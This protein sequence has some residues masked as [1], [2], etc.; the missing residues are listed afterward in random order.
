MLL[1]AGRDREDVR[2]EDDV[3]RRQAD[4]LREDAISAR[5]DLHLAVERVRLA[6]LVERHHHNRRAVPLDQ[7]RVALEGLLTFFQA[8]RVHDRLA[9]HA[10][11]PFLD[12]LPLRAVHHQR[13][14]RDVRFGGDQLQERGH[15]LLRVEHG[16]VHVHVH[17]LRAALDLLPGDR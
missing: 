7:A 13:D 16:L 2:V 5:A 15:R 3:L 10:L 4:L 1:D 11:Q 12:H 14:A 8:D 9:L 6:D 17:D